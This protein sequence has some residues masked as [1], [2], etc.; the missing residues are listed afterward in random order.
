MSRYYVSVDGGGT[1][2][3]FAIL[4]LDTDEIKTVIDKGSNY[5]YANGT[6]HT[7]DISDI[8]RDVLANEGI[9]IEEIVKIVYGL[10]GLDS[11]KDR[12][13]LHEVITKGGIPDDKLILM[14][15]CEFGLR[16]IVDET[17]I[18]V[19]TG[20]GGITYA[21]NKD[22]V[23]REAGWGPPYSDLGS[24]TWIGAEFIKE[25]IL[26]LDDGVEDEI[27]EVVRHFQNSEEP[28]Q[29]TLNAFDIP[30]TASLAR[31]CIGLAA[32]GNETC[33]WI[34]NEAAGHIATY[35]ARVFKRMQYEGDELTIVC[36]G[37]IY[38]SPYWREILAQMTQSLLPCKLVWVRPEESAART[39]IDYLKRVVG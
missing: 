11:E 37:G 33:Q 39:G 8:T 12:K 31:D 38:N 3:E 34:V 32:N 13:Y 5:K 6:S 21:I 29:Q 23:V 20:T 27:T 35:I 18:C 2:T 24:G 10:S 17:G 19:V 1:K 28:L 26:R 7:R 14:N 4:N 30:S 9:A 16:G 15:D 25:A 22:I 36:V